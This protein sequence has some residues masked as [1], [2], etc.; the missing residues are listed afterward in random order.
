[1]KDE[2]GRVK[3]EK[4]MHSGFWIRKHGI[5]SGLRSR[6]YIR[7]SGFW[8][9][10]P[11]GGKRVGPPTPAAGAVGFGQ[12]RVSGYNPLRSWAMRR[13]GFGSGGPGQVHPVQGDP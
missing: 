2:G 4:D 9:E 7:D 6:P 10:R 12:A 5:H 3:D 11:G 8:I 1:M 13:L